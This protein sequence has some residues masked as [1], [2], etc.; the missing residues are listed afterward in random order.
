LDAPNSQGREAERLADLIVTE[1]QGRLDQADLDSGDG[2]DALKLYQKAHAEIERLQG[3]LEQ[4]RRQAEQDQAACELAE[5]A[6][7][8]KEEQVQALEQ[9][10]ADLQRRL[11]ARPRTRGAGPQDAVTQHPL[12]PALLEIAQNPPV[13]T[14]ARLRPGPEPEWMQAWRA[15]RVF[16]RTSALLLVLGQTGECRRYLLARMTGE[17]LGLDGKHSGVKR[18]FTHTAQRG[19]IE[20]INFQQIISGR[21]THLLRLTPKGQQAYLFL[22]GAEAAPS[23]LDEMLRRHKSVEHAFLNL[24]AADLLEQAGCSVD[25]FPAEIKLSGKR[26]FLPDLGAISPNGEVLWVEVERDTNKS[27]RDRDKKWAN[28]Y[29]ASGGHLVIVTGDRQAMQHIQSEIV[30]WAEKRPLR[31]WMTNVSE[32]RA[33][34][35]GQDGSFWLYRRGEK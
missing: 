11:A 12:L 16:E 23:I 8:R 7:A 28:Y 14:P 5:A 10:V 9:T 33:G 22:T 35:R 29:E 2:D 20:K 17:R 3:D 6:Q 24:E 34:Q 31:L 4:A 15:E 13:S 1:V 19:L 32:V 26:K 18:S 21:G 27:P 30:F 25:R